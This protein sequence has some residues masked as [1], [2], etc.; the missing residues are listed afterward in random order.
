MYY[1]IGEISSMVSI[2]KD[3]LRYYDEI[4][5]LKP[6]KIDPDN[7]Y[8]YYGPG[9]V[10]AIARILEYKDYG[11]S[12]EQIKGLLASN[13]P[14]TLR[15]ALQ[16]QYDTLILQKAGL[17]STLASLKRKLEAYS[18]KKTKILIVDDAEFI[19]KVVTQLL[20]NHGGYEALCAENSAQALELCEAESPDLVLMDIA[21]PGGMDGIQCTAQI[22]ALFP[23]IKVVMLSARDSD[24]NK[25]AA[26][27]AGACG[28]IAKPFTG[29]QLLDYLSGQ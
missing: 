26:H 10:N 16:T 2:S 5:V 17:E 27:K 6:D 18:M 3:T 7:G 23:Q 9:Q 28:F 12:L 8:R 13:N 25:A 11:L 24:E 21:M 15:A 4:G 19:R 20:E 29:E 22:K 1:T 14:E